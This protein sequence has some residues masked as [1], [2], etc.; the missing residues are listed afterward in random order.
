VQLSEIEA[1]LAHAS[2]DYNN[3]AIIFDPRQAAG[4]MQRLRGQG[5]RVIEYSFTAA[6]VGRLAVGLHNALRNRALV[7][8]DDPDLI[9]ELSDVRI[10]ETSP[11]TYR[12]NHD[13]GQHDDRAISLALCIQH[14]LH[15]PQVDF[16]AIDLSGAQVGVGSRWASLGPSWRDDPRPV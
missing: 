12:L 14:L 10:R 8:P 1:W 7:L 15:K 6:S 11:N 3:A 16:K 2:S 9:D 5:V 4:S 13:Q